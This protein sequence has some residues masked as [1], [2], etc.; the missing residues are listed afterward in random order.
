VV[1]NTQKVYTIDIR[2]I[3]YTMV[4]YGYRYLQIDM[5]LYRRLYSDVEYQAI[6]IIRE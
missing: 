3:E 4:I 6:W 2:M 1:D 5:D